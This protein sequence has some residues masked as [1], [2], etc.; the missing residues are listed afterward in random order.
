MEH[1]MSASG[2]LVLKC[3]SSDGTA[4]IP[5][6]HLGDGPGTAA[7]ILWAN[8]L[9]TTRQV[10]VHD[11]D[12]VDTCTPSEMVLPVTVLSDFSD[13]TIG[14]QPPSEGG[15]FQTADELWLYLAPVL[16]TSIDLT[17]ASWVASGG[18]NVGRVQVF[19]KA[20]G[21]GRPPP[22]LEEVEADPCALLALTGFDQLEGIGDAISPA[23]PGV[24]PQTFDPLGVIGPMLIRIINGS[25]SGV[26]LDVEYLSE[27]VLSAI[28][29]HTL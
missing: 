26:S 17:L 15:S 22:T 2:K 7:V 23:P 5:I 25:T 13:T 19:V 6:Q 24:Y 21:W 14:A 27:A 20:E 10:E 16:V 11:G 28:T 18:S 8:V 4:R 3:L 1:G 12:V 9:H 29:V